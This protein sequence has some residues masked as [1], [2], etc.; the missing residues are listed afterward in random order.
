MLP[1]PVSAYRVLAETTRMIIV[2]LA[3]F[4]TDDDAKVKRNAFE[5]SYEG[6]AKL[7]IHAYEV[8]LFRY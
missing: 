6:Y 7:C 3:R 2:C 4:A 5:C 1:P 8:F